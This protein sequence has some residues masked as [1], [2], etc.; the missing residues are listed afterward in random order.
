M[1]RSSKWQRLRVGPPRSKQSKKVC[2]KAPKTC[3]PPPVR[4]EVPYLELAKCAEAERGW[5]LAGLAGL[6]RVRFVELAVSLS[7]LQ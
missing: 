7:H 2:P 6:A 3:P 4:A 1:R 5:G